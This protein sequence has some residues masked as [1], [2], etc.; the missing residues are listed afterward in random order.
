MK[1]LSLF[2]GIGGIDL[3]CEWAGIETV[4]FCEKEPFPQRVLRKHWP[5]VPIY[6]DVCTLTKERLDADGIRTIDLIHGGYPCQPFSTAGKR[7]GK[8]DDRHLWP[9]YFRLVQEIR[10]RWV[11][12]ENVAGH[13]SLGLDI[14]LADLESEGYTARS[15]IIPACGVNAPHRRE[16]VFVVAHNEGGSN[17]GLSVGMDDFFSKFVA[18][19]KGKRRGE[20]W[21]YQSERKKERAS[22]S[23]EAISDPSSKGL[24]IGRQSEWAE[25][26]AET[27]S[28]ME[29]ESKR[30]SEVVSHSDGAGFKEQ[31]SSS[32]TRKSRLFTR[33][34]SSGWDHWA[35][36]PNVGRVANGVLKRVDRL[37]SLGNAVVPQQ[38][39]P[40][41]AAIMEIES[42][43]I[44]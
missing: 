7:K 31:H 41:L 44:R 30:C 1:A 21:K 14:V 40:I 8:E 19:S 27:K 5:S 9:E 35:I 36:E 16:R 6:D 34:T 28:R 22:G 12:G 25:I 39:Y 3:A 37:K 4:A 15:F 23:S 43:N 18:N 29:S 20:A 17:R 42:V 26:S 2:S 38:I 10:P 11:V 33:G 24:S 13:V 32:I